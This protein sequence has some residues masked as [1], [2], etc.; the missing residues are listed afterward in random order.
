MEALQTLLFVCLWALRPELWEPFHAALSRFAPRI[1]ATLY[2]KARPCRPWRSA[3]FGGSPPRSPASGRVDVGASYRITRAAT[4]LDRIP[5]CVRRHRGVPARRAGR[6]RRHRG[7]FS[8]MNLCVD[9]FFP[10]V[11]QQRTVRPEGLALSEAS[12]EP[13]ALLAIQARRDAGRGRARRPRTGCG[14]ADR[15]DAAQ[16]RP[17]RF[18]GPS[19][20]CRRVGDCCA[21]TRATSKLR[22]CRAAIGRAGTFA[23][24]VAMRRGLHG[25]RAGRVRTGRHAEA[26]GAWPHVDEA[27]AAASSGL[28]P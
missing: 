9:D 1:P 6:R 4:Y 23:S 8:V 2:L 11:D 7:L 25:P 16:G 17:R 12:R 22:T 28:A 21:G 15:R 5:D 26:A 3:G 13:A 24:H 19:C 18:A 14:C 27:R 10:A 20:S